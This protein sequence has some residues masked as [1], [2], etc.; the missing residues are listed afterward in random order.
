MPSLPAV[1]SDGARRLL[2]ER[3]VASGR[4]LSAVD[5]DLDPNG[6]LYP[7]RGRKTDIHH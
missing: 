4:R 3:R 6:I 7:F 5:D 1:F 2:G